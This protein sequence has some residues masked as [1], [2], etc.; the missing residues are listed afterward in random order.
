MIS[1]DVDLLWQQALDDCGGDPQK[2]YPRYAELII[3]ATVNY[4]LALGED[5]DWIQPRWGF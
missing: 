3:Q 2:A 4:G 1:Q 5:T